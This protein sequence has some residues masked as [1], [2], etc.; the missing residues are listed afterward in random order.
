VEK[1]RTCGRLSSR[2]SLVKCESFRCKKIGGKIEI[3][4]F[5][6]GSR[7]RTRVP[8]LTTVSPSFLL[9]NTSRFLHPPDWSEISRFLLVRTV[10]KP[11][12]EKIKKVVQKNG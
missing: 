12:K 1:S 4:K 2:R 8:H 5:G 3:N 6:V 7:P 11:K 10:E 9:S